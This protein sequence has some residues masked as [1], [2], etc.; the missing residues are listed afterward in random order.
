MIG[1]N[2]SLTPQKSQMLPAP[3]ESSQPLPRRSPPT[4]WIQKPQYIDMNTTEDS[5]GNTMARGYQAADARFNI[6]QID[7]AGISRGKGQKFIAAQGGAQA[8]A[9]AAS[10][11]AQVRGDDDKANAQMRSAY[12][13]QVE[14]ERQNRFMNQH[15]MDQSDWA[16]R[17]AQQQA[18][19]NTALAT[20]R[21]RSGWLNGL[22]D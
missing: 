5:A 3:V 6:K 10:Q 14:Q 8:M 17:F 2:V 16:R 21:G 7:R 4:P 11:A 15:A 1:S 20:S 12:E 22:L 9:Q 18:A 19:F 13:Q